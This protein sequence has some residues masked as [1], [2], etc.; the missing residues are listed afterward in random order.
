MDSAVKLAKYDLRQ[1]VAGLEWRLHLAE[2]LR[3]Q[4]PYP[5]AV[6]QILERQRHERQQPPPLA[7]AVPEKAK[8]FSVR[9]ARLADYDE[10]TT[11][12][13]HTNDEQ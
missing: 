10:L 8:Q 6:R 2:A 13:D 12:G 3:Q 7:V 5:E 9:P 11:Q 4:A 1:I